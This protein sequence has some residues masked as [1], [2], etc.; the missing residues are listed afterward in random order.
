MTPS[1][2]PRHRVL[3]DA[4]TLVER[5]HTVTLIAEAM[6]ADP[7]WHAEGDLGRRRVAKRL[8]FVRWRRRVA[9]RSE[10]DG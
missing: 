5:A 2:A 10:R 8:A 9:G 6:T 3:V 4:E 7:A 1:T